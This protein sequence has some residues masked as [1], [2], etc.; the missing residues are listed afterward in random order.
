MLLDHL[1][2]FAIGFMLYRIKTSTGRQWQNILGVRV[3][4]GIFHTI[5]NSKH[6]PLASALIIGLVTA[7]AYGRIPLLR[8][9]P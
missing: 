2:I 9:Q 7:T 4:V 5:A 1:P 6:N 8:F 3:A